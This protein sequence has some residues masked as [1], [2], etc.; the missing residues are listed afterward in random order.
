V[1]CRPIHPQIKA[2]EWEGEVLTQQLEKTADERDSVRT[3]FESSVHDV[4]QKTGGWVGVAVRT[5][6]L[7]SGCVAVQAA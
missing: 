3:R 6:G 1:F 2:L 7:L 4:Q 5:G